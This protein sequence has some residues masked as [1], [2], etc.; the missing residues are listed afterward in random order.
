[1]TKEL[2]LEM[3]YGSKELFKSELEAAGI[4]LDHLIKI[5]EIELRLL[6]EHRKS[7]AYVYKGG[8]CD[9]DEEETLEHILFSFRVKI[10][11]KK[12]NLKRY[13]EWLDA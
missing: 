2:N 13:K 5:K 3:Y 4:S 6:R 1:M 7:F 10:D 9:S 8:E 11:K 12:E